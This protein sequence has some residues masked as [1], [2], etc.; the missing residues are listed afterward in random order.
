MKCG[1]RLGFDNKSRSSFTSFTPHTVSLS[2]AAL[3]V[4]HYK[5]GGPSIFDKTIPAFLRY[6]HREP[7]ED[8]RTHVSIFRPHHILE[9]GFHVGKPRGGQRI[10]RL[11]PER[12]VSF[13]YVDM[14][15][16]RCEHCKVEDDTMGRWR[17]RWNE[18]RDAF[19][20]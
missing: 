10:L 12:L 2:A 14:F 1:M 5:F 8:N 15:H 4:T 6:W 19:G 18:V 11:D 7:S 3:E 20:I 17:D 9:T 13:H 16:A